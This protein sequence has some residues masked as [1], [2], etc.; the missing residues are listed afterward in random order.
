MLALT[1][2]DELRIAAV[3]RRQLQPR[4]GPIFLGLIRTEAYWKTMHPSTVIRR[5]TSS[6]RLGDMLALFDKPV[7][8]PL[9]ARFQTHLFAS[10]WMI[11]TDLHIVD[12]SSFV[13]LPVDGIAAPV[14]TVH[15]S[16]VALLMNID[17]ERGQFR[18]TAA[19]V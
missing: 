18:V 13:D 1:A 3:H 15:D 12:G 5:A 7:D 17:R 19:V 2:L 4:H 16:H 6:F 8:Y 10:I 9:L 14:Y 11:V